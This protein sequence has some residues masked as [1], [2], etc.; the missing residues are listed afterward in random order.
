M[1]STLASFPAHLFPTD[2][3]VIPVL[4]YIVVAG[5]GLSLDDLRKH[6]W[7]FNL[8]DGASREP[9]YK[10]YSYLGSHT[11]VLLNSGTRLTFF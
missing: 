3:I 1:C 6:G 2:F 10:V 5:A 11:R 4:F 9:W 8:G 7:L